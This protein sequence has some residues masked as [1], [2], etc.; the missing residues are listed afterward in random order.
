MGDYIRNPGKSREKCKGFVNRKIRSLRVSGELDTEELD[1]R[2][3]GIDICEKGGTLPAI[4]DSRLD[5][6]IIFG[7]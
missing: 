5:V 3:L 1:T 6:E 4:M 7:R 2:N